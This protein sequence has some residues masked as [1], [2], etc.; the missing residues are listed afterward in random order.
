MYSLANCC[1]GQQYTIVIAQFRFLP[2]C[3][4]PRTFPDAEQGHIRRDDGN[5]GIPMRRPGTP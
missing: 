5:R 4:Q 3:E 2:F 1:F